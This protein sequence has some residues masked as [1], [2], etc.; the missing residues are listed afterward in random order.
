MW[1]NFLKA[2]NGRY[3]FQDDFVLAQDFFLFTDVAGSWGFAAIWRSHWRCGAWPEAW[4]QK[5]VTR[6]IVLLELFPVVVALELWG[7]HFTDCRIL[8]STDNNGVLFAV[9]CKNPLNLFQ[10]F[11]S[12]DIWFFFALSSTSGLRPDMLLVNLT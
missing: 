8:V 5:K 11:S 10:L 6:N 1:A 9:N 2:Y 12:C 3:F 7:A 4:M